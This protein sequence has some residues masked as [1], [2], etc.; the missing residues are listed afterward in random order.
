MSRIFDDADRLAGAIVDKVGKKI[1]LGLPVGIGKAIHVADALFERAA[2]DASVDLTIFTGLTL[3]APRAGSELERRFLEPLA[4]R[5]YDRWPTPKYA[6]AQRRGGLP[7]NIRVHE[8]Y[9]RPGAFLGNAVVQRRYSSINYSHVVDALLQLGVN[10]VAQLVAA[11]PASPGFYSLGSNPEITLDLLPRLEAQRRGGRRVALVGQ[12]NREMPYMPGAGELAEARFD[13]VLKGERYEFPM[14]PLP[15]RPV[16]AADFATG[17]HVASLVRDGGTLQVGIGSLSDAVAHCVALRHESPDVFSDVLERLP[18]GTSSPRRAV[19]PVE[20]G[21]FEIGL[22]ASTELMSDAVFSLFERGIVRRPAGEGDAAAIHAGFFIGSSRFYERL[23][24]LGDGDRDRIH[25]LPISHVN[26]LYG[27]EACKRRQRRDARFINEAMIVT[28]LGAAISDGL[29]DGRVVSGVG[30]QFDFVSMGLE[31]DDARS[32]LMCRARR[33]ASGRAESNLRWQYGHA[34]VP[35]HHRDVYVSEYGIAATRGRSDEQVID[36]MLAIADSEFQ[37]ALQ[38]AAMRARK[39]GPNHRIADDARTNTPEALQAVFDRE[40]VRPHFPAYPL[41]SEF[42]ETER[43]LVSALGWLEN[44]MARPA[45]RVR[46]TLAAIVGGHSTAHQSALARMGL[47]DASGVR[48][49]LLRRLVA[50]A[51]EETSA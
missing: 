17:M 21:P 3:E 23:R 47:A 14:F 36:A 8:F 2:Q 45:S 50:H 12:V 20:T 16:A 19:L 32:V 27:D 31:L 11:R 7:A 49:R 13:F 46:T 22:F 48:E 25:M 39:L 41:G 1:V 35:R 40:D 15:P 44:A 24:G 42:T 34:T 10:V 38:A 33:M 26:T 43:A 30:G 28:L 9:L 4:A 5:L 29:E 18:G 6:A 37:P 51:L